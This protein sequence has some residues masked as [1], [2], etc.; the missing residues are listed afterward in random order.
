[1]KY[2]LHSCYQDEFRQYLDKRKLETSYD[3]YRHVRAIVAAFDH[4]LA[5]K[6]HFGKT[7]SID[8]LEEWSKSLTNGRNPKTV[9]SYRSVTRDLMKYMITRGFQCPLPESMLT[10]SNFSPYIYSQEELGR[11]I[12][13]ADN[14]RIHKN[15]AKNRWLEIEIPMCIRILYGCGLRAGEVLRL[16]MKDVDLDRSYF[17]IK[18]AK[19]DKQR[20]VPFKESLRDI[21]RQY[22]TS[23]GIIGS[24][25]ALLFPGKDRDV[26]LYENSLRNHFDAIRIRCGIS[27][28]GYGS[29]ERGPCLHSFR[30]VF[31]VTSFKAAVERGVVM[32]DVFPYLSTYL[33]HDSLYET[34]KY[35]KFSGDLFPDTTEKFAAF[36]TDIFPEVRFDE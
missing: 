7:I 3:Y 33:G 24:P 15:Y 2:D 23:M 13:E 20:I 36:A 22:C 6:Q 8:L 25:D 28:K 11:I 4:Y 19:N 32:N 5:G 12:H 26:P 9:E 30:H 29:H 34:E 17:V 14:Y 18:V 31:A 1:M 10:R 27:R 16:R 35:L 21:L